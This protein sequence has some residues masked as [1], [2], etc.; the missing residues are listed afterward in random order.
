MSKPFRILIVFL[1]VAGF[2][3][4]VWLKEQHRGTAANDPPS[5]AA[6]PPATAPPSMETDDSAALPRLV[7]LGSTHCVPCK[8][9]APIL[10]ELDAEYRDQ[11]EVVV[12]DVRED[13]S[14]ARL[15]GIRVIPTQ[16]FYNA[17]GEELFRHEGFMSKEAILEQ[18]QTLGIS[19][20]E[21]ARAA[22]EG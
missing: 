11:F 18:W 7:D 21:R 19:I 20:D 6:S 15:Y 14:A 17:E 13:R 1:V 3:T 22:G 5:S 9:M 12:I 16:I 4:M 10:E 2:A 8:M